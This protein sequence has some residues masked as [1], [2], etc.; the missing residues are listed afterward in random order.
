MERLKRL[1]I[2][3]LTNNLGITPN[4]TPY[5][6]VEEIYNFVFDRSHEV[7]F[8][9]FDNKTYIISDADCEFINFTLLEIHQWKL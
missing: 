9:S 5:V 6:T 8:N 4:M 3:P 2:T 1:N 7:A